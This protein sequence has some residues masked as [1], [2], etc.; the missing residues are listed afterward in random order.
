MIDA[1]HDPKL[2]SWVTSAQEPGCDFP[3][4]N[5]PLGIFQPRGVKPRAG[6]AIGD[7]ILDVSEWVPGETLN[8]Y[9][10]LPRSRRRELRACPLRVRPPARVG[11]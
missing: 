1:T 3:I 5:L 8:G 10:G 9:C 11:L 4:Q 2:T 7:S 6:V